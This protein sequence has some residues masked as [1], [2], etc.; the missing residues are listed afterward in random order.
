MKLFFEISPFMHQSGTIYVPDDLPE[1]EWEK[2]IKKNLSKA[3]LGEMDIS[4]KGVDID[5][6]EKDAD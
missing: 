6:I 2:Y 5:Y 4:Y 1:A 3:S